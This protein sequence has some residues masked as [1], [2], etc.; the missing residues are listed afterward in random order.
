MIISQN[1]ANLEI[2]VIAAMVEARANATDNVAFEYILDAAQGMAIDQ[3]KSEGASIDPSALLPSPINGQRAYAAYMGSFT[4]PPCAEGVHW[5]IFQEPVVISVNQL[6]RYMQMT[7]QAKD[8]A[9]G[10]TSN[11]NYAEI[12]TGGMRRSV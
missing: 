5:Q 11:H 12:I 10:K 4:T 7:G 8:G 9:C 6:W 1:L 2:Y 3:V